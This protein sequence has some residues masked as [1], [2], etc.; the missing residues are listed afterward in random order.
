MKPNKSYTFVI[1]KCV[2]GSPLSRPIKILQPFARWRKGNYLTATNTAEDTL[3][4]GLQ[5]F[6][7]SVRYENQERD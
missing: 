7:N 2:S 1:P 3:G 4:G 5:I 6:L